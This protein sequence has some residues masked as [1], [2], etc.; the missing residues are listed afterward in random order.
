MEITGFTP[1]NG[2]PGTT[3]TLSLT[4]VPRNATQSITQVTLGE[5]V[6]GSVDEVRVESDGSGTVTVTIEQ[7]SQSGQFTVVVLSPRPIAAARS[8]EVFTVLQPQGRPTIT[9]I[10]PREVAA[11]GRHGDP[12]RKQSREEDIMYVSVGTTRAS[13]FAAFDGTRVRFLVLVPQHP[14]PAASRRGDP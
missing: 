2:G 9:S 14:R 12:H 4:G 5:T 1:D 6:L 10:S 13:S 7:T 11:G 3:V 8:S